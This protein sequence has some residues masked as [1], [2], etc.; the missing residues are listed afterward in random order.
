MKKAGKTLGIVLLA[1]V[2]SLSLRSEAMGAPGQDWTPASVGGASS[3][4]QPSATVPNVL[5]AGN[6]AS[7]SSIFKLQDKGQW[8]A[9][10]RIIT[11]LR[12]DTLMAD[13]LAQ[14]YLSSRG[15]RATSAELNAWMERNADHPDA[16][17]VYALA[18]QR[19]GKDSASVPRPEGDGGFSDG[20]RWRKATPGNYRN[21]SQAQ[22]QQVSE[23]KT[24]FQDTL[25]SGD[26]KAAREILETEETKTLLTR[27]DQDRLRSLLSFSYFVDGMD[28]PA[29]KTAKVASPRTMARWTSGL[30][31][32]RQGRM[33]VARGHFE[34]LARDP[35][36]SS[37]LQAA[38]GYWAART[39]LKDHRP[40]DV[41][42][43][44]AL[45]AAHPRTFY[46]LLARRSL[47]LDNR[48][49]WEPAGLSAADTDL[50]LESPTGRR[51]IAL[52]QVGQKDRAER[53][54]RQIYP[55]AS[56]DE[57]RAVV[58]LAQKANMASLAMSLGSSG[59]G[60]EAD[61][62][63]DAAHFP[64][65][66]WLPEGG[67]RIDRALVL[68]LVRQESR[69]IPDAKS[70][71]GARGLMQLMPAT[72]AYVARISGQGRHAKS[73]LDRPETNL[74]LGQKYVERLLQDPA[75][76]GNLLLMAAAYNAGPGNLAKWMDRAET[77]N[78]P[79]LFLES[80]PMPETRMF[81]ER[82]LTNFWMY[83]LRLDQPT[84]S[85]DALAS[86]DWPQYVPHDDHSRRVAE[87]VPH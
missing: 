13:V 62:A 32:W 66:T 47:G 34:S 1:G 27:T 14:R 68:A 86:G 9:A 73:A 33:D 20:A 43:W 60:G 4:G 15:F 18:V 7:Y 63:N 37:W 11:Q 57:A 29:Q 50:L 56:D 85:L 40:Q 35:D 31:A 46:G 84:P 64:V 76:N 10:D 59:N 17:E 82:V 25:R 74:M 81:V 65:P 5:S 55:T 28:G 12:D 3:S 78:D 80:I 75:I 58:A 6:S 41:N 53:Q 19:A 26:T 71:V 48:F 77:Q 42:R 45:A 30:S 21:L 69:F 72:A 61:G 79:L 51:V 44:L 23:I 52:I 67:W 38:G 16:A 2:M 83:S 39:N 54:L 87:N 36:A 49:D 24:R 22:R 70:P 8:K